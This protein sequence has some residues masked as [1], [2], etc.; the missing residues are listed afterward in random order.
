MTDR[1]D[2][3]FSVMMN[4]LM[5]EGIIVRMAC[6]STTLAMAFQYDRP[7]LR[8]ASIWP[9]STLSIPARIISA[10][11]APQFSAR[12]MVPACRAVSVS[13]VLMPSMVFRCMMLLSSIGT[14]K[15]T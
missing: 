9:L 13:C 15:N 6:G 11:Y 1:M 4:W 3:S 8:A 12:Q 5:M 14:A 2:V 10:M 7:R